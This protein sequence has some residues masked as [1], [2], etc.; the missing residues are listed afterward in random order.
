MTRPAPNIAYLHKARTLLV[1]CLLGLLATACNQGAGSATEPTDSAGQEAAEAATYE[2]FSRKDESHKATTKP[3]SGYSK[4]QLDALPMVKKIV[5]KVVV[6]ESFSA[7]QTVPTIEK[8]I[9]DMSSND[10]DIDEIQVY[11]YSEESRL[12]GDYDVAMGIWA[13]DGKLGTVD[14]A[15]ATG[16]NHDEYS[17]K[18]HLRQNLQEN[19]DRRG[20]FEH[21]EMDGLTEEDKEDIESILEDLENQ[22][23][24]NPVS[25]LR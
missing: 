18:S 21:N 20:K 16:N 11:F 25:P 6:P 24:T 17:I 7:K 4:E 9:A 12:S 5:Y 23:A 2:V 13:P 22:S 10:K 1:L 15:T 3:I 19:L 8:F 14:A